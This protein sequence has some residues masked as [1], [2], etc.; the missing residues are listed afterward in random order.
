MIDI[1]RSRGIRPV[2]F[3]VLT[4][5]LAVLPSPLCAEGFDEGVRLYNRGEYGQAVTLFL[6]VR[7]ASPEDPEVRVWLGKSYLK[8]REWDKAVREMEKASQLRP[9]DAQ[10]RLWLGRACGAK[11][12]NTVF[13]RA[14]GWARRLLKEFE[15]AR[16]LAPENLEARFDLLDFY[17]NAPGM[18]GG[19]KDKAEA[20][21]RAI[22]KLSPR[23]GYVA[24]AEILRHENKWDL[25]KKELL[26]AALDFPN[27]ADAYKD[28]AGF[29][30]ERQDFEGAAKHG[31]KALALRKDSKRSR[32]IVAAAGI[33]LR[34]GLDD[35]ETALRELASGPLTDSDPSFE[36]VYYWLGECYTAK[37]DKRKAREAFESALAYN[38]DY[39]K[40]KKELSKLR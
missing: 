2:K 23:K 30:L 15:S 3:L 18:V 17:L 39:E 27:D 6:K 8:I 10:Y 36:E 24:R 9:T 5:L 20:E 14:L 33:Q 25:A 38:P 35:S 11:A 22:S 34:A 16:A 40:A 31:T 26:Q 4:F 32:L 19:G 7:E 21:A 37:G 1:F 12:S 29:L 28:L 13:F